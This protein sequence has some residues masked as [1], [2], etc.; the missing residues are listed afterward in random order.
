MP[1][2]LVMIMTAVVYF[3]AAFVER[4]CGFGSGIFA[5]LFL[6]YF[7]PNQTVGPAILGL[8]SGVGCA[9]NALKNRKN[10]HIKTMLPVVAAALVSIP[11]SCPLLS[12]YL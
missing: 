3:G 4:V 11:M 8:M 1:D 5:M 7:L 2:V 12:A 9:Y 10:I 6:P